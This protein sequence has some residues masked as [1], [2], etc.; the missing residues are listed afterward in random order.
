MG[1]LAGKLS[2]I[3][4]ALYPTSGVTTDGV[5]LF[6]RRAA[7]AIRG[8]RCAERIEI[9]RLAADGK[10][11]H[12]RQ[13][14]WPVDVVIT[15]AGLSP[16]TDLVQVSGCPL[17]HI[18]D[19]GGWVPVHNQRLE[20]PLKGLFVAGSITGIEGSEVAEA[21]G[22]LAGISAARFLGLASS[23]KVEEDIIKYQAAVKAARKTSLPFMPDIKR[24]RDELFRHID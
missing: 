12:H 5:R 9:S 3:A 18:P 15:S 20:T 10:V 13:E 21:L 22:R 23:P 17:V 11:T 19:L 2:G 6:L 1:K 24:G 4:A 16:L 7:R 14:N 8:E